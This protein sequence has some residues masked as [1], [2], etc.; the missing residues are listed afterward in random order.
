[1]PIRDEKRRKKREYA[2]VSVVGIL[3]LCLIGAAVFWQQEI[4]VYWRFQPWQVGQYQALLDRLHSGASK[5]DTALVEA[6]VNP[7][8]IRIKTEDG[9]P[10]LEYGHAQMTRTISFR[11]FAARG[12]FRVEGLE[13]KFAGEGAV[14]VRAV[15]KNGKPAEF[16]VE[17]GPA[18]SR[19]I[20]SLTL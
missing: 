5:S 8:S 19:R 4:G 18:S 1:M 10:V 14:L 20:S 13:P 7:E 12:P 2:I 3:V 16:V 9:A 6:C 11:D 17:S 15:D